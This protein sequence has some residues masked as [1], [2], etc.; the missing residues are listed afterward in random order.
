M[1]GVLIVGGGVGGLA[2]ALALTQRRVDCEIIEVQPA[3]QAH[4]TGVYMP[5]NGV[6]AL[7]KLGVGDVAVESG[8][9]IGRREFATA[10][11]RVVMSLDL[12]QVWGAGQVCLGIRRP[13]LHAVLVEALAGTPVTM[14][15]TV[16]EIRELDDRVDVVLTDGGVRSYDVVVGADG[17]NSKVRGLILGDVPVRRVLERTCRYLTARP[18]GVDDWSLRVGPEGAILVVP[19]GVDEAY[20]YAQRP[21]EAASSSPT[22]WMA[23]FSDFAEP[24]PS[25]LRGW[26]VDGAYWDSL[27]ELDA[28][29]V[30]GRGR[31]VLIGDAA[32]A[33]PPFMAQ[34]AALALEDA[35]AL[36][37][38][39]TSADHL[40]EVAERLTE[41]RSD[42]VAWVRSRNRRREKLARVPF[43]LAVIGAKLTGARTW[44]ED[45]RPLRP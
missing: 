9:R 33:M 39:V 37:D 4:G 6:D 23:P 27:E 29:P 1:P 43:P 21:D 25:A 44:T 19:V 45:Y 35:L 10:G 13:T 5:A 40:S 42:R 22:E 14:G 3:W 34:G 11:G 24:I 15:T 36:A 30:W 41:R 26:S 16:A 28:I 7:R 8:A 38:V 20:V 17:A 31:V 18:G 32:H 2:A 12:E